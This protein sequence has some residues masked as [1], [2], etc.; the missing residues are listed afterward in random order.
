MPLWRTSMTAWLGCHITRKV[1]DPEK[2]VVRTQLRAKVLGSCHQENNVVCADVFTVPKNINTTR[3]WDGRWEK[4][5]RTRKG[6]RVGAVTSNSFARINWLAIS[7]VNRKL[8]LMSCETLFIK[9]TQNMEIWL[10]YFQNHSPKG[11]GRGDAHTA[12]FLL[13]ASSGWNERRGRLSEVHDPMVHE[14][15]GINFPS[16][17]KRPKTDTIGIEHTSLQTNTLGK[18]IL[19]KS[20]ALIP[21]GESVLI[22]ANGYDGLGTNL[23]YWILFTKFCAFDCVY[24][25]S[26]EWRYGAGLFDWTVWWP[27]T[28]RMD[29]TKSSTPWWGMGYFFLETSFA[30]LEVRILER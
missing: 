6:T 8:F 19:T 2:N 30:G 10:T 25:M 28:S 12:I 14:S 17:E 24:C 7:G 21:D 11:R 13:K 29:R 20:L 26:W 1:L 5:I 18:E 16:D 15:H 23:D 3:R 4:N 22:V 27:F 9:T